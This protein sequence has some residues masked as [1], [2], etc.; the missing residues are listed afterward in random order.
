[1]FV[2]CWVA[3]TRYA[4]L[5][6]LLLFY[7]LSGYDFGPMDSGVSVALVNSVPSCYL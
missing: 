4:V 5:C 7:A 2:C 3:N 6:C 1:M